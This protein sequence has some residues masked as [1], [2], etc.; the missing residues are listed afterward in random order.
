MTMLTVFVTEVLGPQPSDFKSDR[1]FLSDLK[2]FSKKVLTNKIVC[3]IIPYVVRAT[4]Y[5]GVA[6]W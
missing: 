1:S 5:A 6:Q 2:N 3:A 4:R